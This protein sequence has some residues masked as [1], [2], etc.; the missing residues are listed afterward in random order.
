MDVQEATP[1]VFDSYEKEDGTRKSEYGRYGRMK[2]AYGGG[3][4]A[5]NKDNNEEAFDHIIRYEDGIKSDFVLASCSI[6]VN[7]NYTRLNVGT[8]NLAVEGQ[9]ND[10]TME[11]INRPSISYFKNSNDTNLRSFWDGGLLTNTPLRQTY[12][13]HIDYWQPIKF[14]FHSFFCCTV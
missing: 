2:S 1:V 14:L 6:P 5:N 10:I 9:G 8:R 4:S 12:I 7:Y 11:D 13:V 3:G